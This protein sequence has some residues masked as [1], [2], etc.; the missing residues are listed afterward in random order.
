MGSRGSGNGTTQGS[1]RRNTGS[2]T[3]SGG[4]RSS[5]DR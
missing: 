2:N 5:H 3:S 4:R 1:N